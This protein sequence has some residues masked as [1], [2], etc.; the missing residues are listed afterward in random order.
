MV[1]GAHTPLSGIHWLM[2]RTKI[3]N[4]GRGCEEPVGGRARKVTLGHRGPGWS[5]GGDQGSGSTRDELVPGLRLQEPRSLTSRRA[6]GVQPK[7]STERR[8]VS[9]TGPWEAPAEQNSKHSSE[10]KELWR[11]G[12]DFLPWAFPKAK[13][14]ILRG[15]WQTLQG[16]LLEA[17]TKL[18]TSP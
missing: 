16:P 5:E 1:R 15:S 6:R 7:V 4:D 2:S 11:H 10:G 8:L 12:K 14:Q 9:P 13:G 18:F 3:T 17:R